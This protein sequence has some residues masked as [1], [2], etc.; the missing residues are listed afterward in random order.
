V[1]ISLYN[2]VLSETDQFRDGRWAILGTK[3][4]SL[5][6]ET[7]SSCLIVREPWPTG[8]SLSSTVPAKRGRVGS[9]DAL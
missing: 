1:R 9:G 7:A 2:V 5:L 4:Y 6:P 3:P 8:L